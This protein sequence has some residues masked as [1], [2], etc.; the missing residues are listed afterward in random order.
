MK[1]RKVIKVMVDTGMMVL[2]PL[3]MAYSLIGETAH[4]W[5][6]IAMFLLF[7]L[8]H[9]LNIAWLKSLFRGQYTPLRAYLTAIN[10]LLLLIMVLQPVSGILLSK[11]IFHLSGL[12][13]MSVAR[14]THLLLSHWGFVLLSL[15]I[16]NHAG[17]H[18]AKRNGKAKHGFPFLTILA[19]AVS[20]YGVYAFV[21]RDLGSHLFLHS[22]FVFFDPDASRLHFLADYAAMMCLFACI[23][24]ALSRGLRT[25][26]LPNQERRPADTN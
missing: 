1:S 3:L 25:L 15:H 22:Q 2:L 8:H 5:L 19:L 16:G 14:T 13:G 10:I 17:A 20:L 7:V 26:R 4:E 12:G 6:G 23:G 24:A 21:R 11:H 18:P 9:A